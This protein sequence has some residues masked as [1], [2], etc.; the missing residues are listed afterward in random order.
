MTF[1]NDYLWTPFMVFSL[2]FLLVKFAG[3]RSVA[4]MTAFD[5]MFIQIMGTAI[6]E[7]IVSKNNW[8]AAWYS[9]SIALLYIILSRLALVNKLKYWISHSPTVLIRK[10]DIDEHGL[11]R[12]RLTVDELQGILRTKGYTDILDVEIAVMEESGQVSIIPMSDKRPLQPS[13]LNI[14][15]SP[16]FISIPLIMDGDIIQHNLKFVHKSLDWLYSQMMNHQLGKEDLHKITL[17]TYNQKGDVE[18]DIKK[19]HDKSINT[20]KPGNEN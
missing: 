17:A 12:V 13:D 2:G 10:G 3:K 7:P 15:P 20:Y 19:E 1:L 8:S 4:Q 6:T 9:F 5:L 14:Q 11:A 16:T 18:F